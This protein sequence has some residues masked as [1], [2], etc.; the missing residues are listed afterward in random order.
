MIV[1]NKSF[2]TGNELTLI[3]EAVETQASGNGKFT[4]LCHEFF[5]DRY[6]FRKVLLTTSCTDALEMAAILLNIKPGDEVIIPSFTFVS[7]ANAFIL[8][9]AKVVFADSMDNNPNIAVDK[10]EGLITSKT[11]AIVVVHYAGISVEMEKLQ[12]LCKK[13]NLFIVEDAAQSIDAYYKQKP[14]GGIGHLG[15]FSFHDTKNISSGEGGLLIINDERFL[16]RSEI[17]WEKGTNRSAFIRGEVD[18]YSWVD[19]GSSFLPSELT[20]AFLYAQLQKIDYIQKERKKIWDYYYEKL[21][22][23]NLKN[24]IALPTIPEAANHNSH[25]FYILCGDLFQRNFVAQILKKNGIQAH[26]H[27]LPLHLSKFHLSLH[28]PVVIP[29]AVKF[30]DGLLRLPLYIGLTSTEQDYIVN[31]IEFALDLYQQGRVK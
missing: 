4:K 20:A 18:K 15:C 27:Y 3:S 30:S 19:M 11:K 22:N 9:G 12:L 13:H 16:E 8:R 29:N 5:Q 1:F 28:N 17:I 2:L 10:L 21:S 26:F 24:K 25:L 23:L 31:K 7:T 6:G 14:L